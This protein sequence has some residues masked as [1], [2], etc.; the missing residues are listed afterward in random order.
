[1]ARRR[2]RPARGRRATRIARH[3]SACCAERQVR[4]RPTWRRARPASAAAIATG[5]SRSWSTCSRTP[6]SSCPRAAAGSMSRL[7]PTRG[8]LEVRVEDNGPGVPGSYARPSS[9][10]SARCGDDQKRQAAGHGPRARDLPPDRRALR[11]PD[12]GRG[13][14]LGGAAFCFTL[15]VR[16][17]SRRLAGRCPGSC[18]RGLSAAPDRLVDGG[19]KDLAQDRHLHRRTR[20]SPPAAS[21]PGQAIRRRARQGRVQARLSARR[22]SSA[23]RPSIPCRSITAPNSER[24]VTIRLTPSTITSIAT[25]L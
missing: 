6:P 19:G 14:G 7:R 22:R 15:P 9:R 2:L 1:M 18:R 17:G 21:H 13:G 23:S 5:W 24:W 10:S 3:R 11:R 16:P 12:L 20:D 4:S 25:R 8:E